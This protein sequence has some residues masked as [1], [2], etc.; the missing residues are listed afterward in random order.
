MKH[1]NDLYSEHYKS[2]YRL[3]FRFLN[4]HESAADISQDVFVY[5]YKSI[6]KNAEIEN[7]KAWLLKV[8][9]NL[10]L[11]H[12][13]KN[14]RILDLRKE[15]QNEIKKENRSNS[16]V[17]LA[18]QQLNDKDRILLTLYSEGLSYKELSETAGIKFTSVGKT[19]SRALKKLKDEV[20][21]RK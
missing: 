17:L 5:L 15:V 10:S 18:L 19:L 16:E 6:T 20:E 21:R 13:R 3:A 7:V 4:D 1:F 14:R 9:S 12:I 8:T 2:V 11:A